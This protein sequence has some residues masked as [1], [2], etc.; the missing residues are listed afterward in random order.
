MSTLHNLSGE[1]TC[2]VPIY[3]I[4]QFHLLERNWK[5]L[6]QVAHTPFADVELGDNINWNGTGEFATKIVE[7]RHLQELDN[8]EDILK[9]Y[10]RNMKA[11]DP[12]M[13]NSVKVDITEEEYIDFWKHKKETTTT[14]PFGLHIGHYRSIL[15]IQHKNILEVHHRLL[16]ILF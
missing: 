13:I 8:K 4:T 6:R 15:E 11:S 14:S 10:I 12:S 9:Q 7:G 1:F 16:M 3:L 2:P 5:H